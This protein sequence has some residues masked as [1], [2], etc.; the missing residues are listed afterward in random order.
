MLIKRG[1]CMRPIKF[2]AWDRRLKNPSYEEWRKEATI[3]RN[4]GSIAQYEKETGKK[5]YDGFV[6]GM[7]YS[8]RAN[9][10]WTGETQ[11]L[12]PVIESIQE[13]EDQE[14]MQFTGLKDRLGKEIYEGDVLKA[15]CCDDCKN[16]Y[17]RV[18]VLWEMTSWSLRRC[19]KDKYYGPLDDRVTQNYEVIGNIYENGD[20][21]K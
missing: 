6:A 8:P 3:D 2:R 18:K 19:Y 7:T 5:F 10:E 11:P 13:D 20:L 4:V 17:H 16:P 14:L 1:D 15:K 9:D 21:L 12:N